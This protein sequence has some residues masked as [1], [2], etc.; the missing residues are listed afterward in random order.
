MKSLNTPFHVRVV[1]AAPGFIGYEATF[2][3]A[4]ELV[5]EA[6]QHDA[7]LV[8]FPESFVPDY[9]ARSGQ[10]RRVRK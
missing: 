10:S 8:A 3:K 5:L 2:D 4:C 9:P 6:A 1:Q 7:R